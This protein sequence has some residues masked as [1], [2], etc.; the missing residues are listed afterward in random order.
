[1]PNWLEKSESWKNRERKFSLT[2]ERKGF[3]ARVIRSFEKK[4]DLRNRE[5]NV[6]FSWRQYAT[7][8]VIDSKACIIQHVNFM[9]PTKTT[10]GDKFH[11]FFYT[12][13][14][15]ALLSFLN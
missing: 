2:T 11:I 12:I 1:M 14:K 13:G 6:C 8:E 5:S 9:K 10:E 7:T 15:I 3:V 4:E